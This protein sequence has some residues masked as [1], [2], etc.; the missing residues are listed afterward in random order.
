MKTVQ[1][2]FCK[3]PIELLVNGKSMSFGENSLVVTDDSAVI[4][5]ESRDHWVNYLFYIG[6]FQC[7]YRDLFDIVEPVYSFHRHQDNVYRLPIDSDFI[8][9]SQGLGEINRKTLLQFVYAY[10]LGMEKKYFSDLLHSLVDTNKGFFE[11]LDETYLNPW[12]VARYADELGITVRKLNI[13]FYEKFGISAKHWLIKRRLEHGR[14]MLLGS[15]VRISDIAMECGFSNHAHFSDCFKK[16]YGYSPTY[17]RE[18]A[19]V[20]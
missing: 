1:F 16:H 6:D 3:G 20:S 4:S 15:Q 5:A 2:I 17:L 14:Q 13:I 18:T 9:V 19:H 10:C 11:Y 12:P 8:R 7:V